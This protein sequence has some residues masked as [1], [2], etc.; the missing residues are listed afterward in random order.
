RDYDKARLLFDT[1]KD[2]GNR[3]DKLDPRKYRSGAR[4]LLGTA[5]LIVQQLR[6]LGHIRD[7]DDMRALARDK[8]ELAARYAKVNADAEALHRA[9]GSL[10][11][12]AAPPVEGTAR[13]LA[14]APQGP[15]AVLCADFGRL[16][17]APP[18]VRDA[19]RGQGPRGPRRRRRPAVPLGEGRHRAALRGG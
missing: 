5:G 2:L 13:D 14:R 4:D 3:V 17:R 18:P 10:P 6:G 9:A 12:R 8:G 7:L 16:D 11:L 15:R 19:R 1:V